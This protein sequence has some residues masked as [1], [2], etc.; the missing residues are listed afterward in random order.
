MVKF[1]VQWDRNPIHKSLLRPERVM[2]EQIERP[3]QRRRSCGDHHGLISGAVQGDGI[4]KNVALQTVPKFLAPVL[5]IRGQWRDP[6]CPWK[7]G[8]DASTGSTP[9]TDERDAAGRVVMHVRGANIASNTRSIAET[10][11]RGEPLI[12][13]DH[14][15]I[16]EILEG[17]NFP[18]PH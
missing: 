8:E 18:L 16:D 6:L 17:E 9:E 7:K 3:I 13:V 2:T 15:R 11:G 1:R 14:R 5:G 12:P 10:D 4:S